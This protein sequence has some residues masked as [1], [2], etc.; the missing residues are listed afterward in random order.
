[1]ASST[2][3][4]VQAMELTGLPESHAR[5]PESFPFH[6]LPARA[7]CL[8]PLLLS[9]FPAVCGSSVRP[10]QGLEFMPGDP[11]AACGMSILLYRVRG[12]YLPPR[13]LP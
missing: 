11:A 10:R 9:S 1:M 4:L 3:M 2:A 12:A 13:A 8:P 5:R 6:G 7:G